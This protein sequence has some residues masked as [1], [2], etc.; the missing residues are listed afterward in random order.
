MQ[1]TQQ[2]QQTQQP[3]EDKEN[4]SLNSNKPKRPLASQNNLG[5]PSTRNIRITPSFKGM[6]SV[7]KKNESGGG[8]GGGSKTSK[9]AFAFHN[10]N[11]KQKKAFGQMAGVKTPQATFE[12]KVS[13]SGRKQSMPEQPLV[14]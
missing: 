2:T 8:V 14:Y 12:V 7:I 10:S 1:Q 4:S 3:L 13:F 11:Q 9:A 5:K 6:S